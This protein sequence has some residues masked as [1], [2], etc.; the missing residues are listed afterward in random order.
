MEIKS[1]IRL[2]MVGLLLLVTTTA[3][4]GDIPESLIAVD[5]AKIYTATVLDVNSETITLKVI[6][7]IKGDVEDGE[8]VSVPYFE[9]NWNT[10][11]NRNDNC[12]IT[13]IDG[14]SYYS[15]KTT[16]TDPENLK[17]LNHTTNKSMNMLGLSMDE[18]FEQY[19]NDGTYERAEKKRLENINVF[20][21]DAEHEKTINPKTN[22]IHYAIYGILAVII[23]L[24]FIL[25]RRRNISN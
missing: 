24:L 5:D 23:V 21:T 2:I 13:Q 7:K 20:S 8:T 1:V 6:H 18:R 14:K 12:V 11:A 17:L 3:Y 15:F 22:D 16:S 10:K 4:A 25:Y 9:F 19:I